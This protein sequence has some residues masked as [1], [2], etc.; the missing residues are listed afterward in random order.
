MVIT[1]LKISELKSF[2][3]QKAMATIDYFISKAMFA[4]PELM[5]GQDPNP[6]HVPKEHI[7]Q[8]I[9][10]ALGV[11]PVG[12]GSYPVDVIKNNE[13]G[14]D[15]KMLSCKVDAGGNL[16]NSD[17]GET[18]LAQKFTDTGSDLDTLFKGK[19]Y[20]IIIDGFKEILK[21]KL[22]KVIKEK[23]INDIYYHLFPVFCLL[24]IF[25][26]YF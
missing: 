5:P 9:V 26:T 22:S 2:F 10:Q 24:C 12:S 6:I 18:S 25:D 14:A 1:P 20:D 7:E 17:S 3:N 23:K 11:A 4:Q 21:N 19:K 15:V 16:R 13:W 8:W